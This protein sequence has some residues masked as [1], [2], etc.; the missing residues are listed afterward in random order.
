[1]NRAIPLAPLLMLA[2]A[3]GLGGESDWPAFRGPAARGVALHDGFPDRWTADEN[4]AWKTDLP[5][6]GWSTP[7]VWGV[8]VFLTTC[9]STGPL[10]EAKKGLYFGGDRTAPIDAVHR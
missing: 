6:R 7:V 8:K 9:E 10:E 5:G 1:M 3:V 4:V 2:A